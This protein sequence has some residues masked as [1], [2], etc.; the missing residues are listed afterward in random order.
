M[1]YNAAYRKKFNFMIIG[2]STINTIQKYHLSVVVSNIF[3]QKNDFQ[4]PVI[5]FCNLKF[6][7]DL[8]GK[9]FKNEFS[10]NKI[11]LFISMI[12]QVKCEMWYFG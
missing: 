3:I 12:S 1:K 7:C 10:S 4:Y 6:T 5:S 9:V 11:K 2:Y 8:G